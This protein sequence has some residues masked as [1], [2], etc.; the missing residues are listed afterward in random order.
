MK[1][2]FQKLQQTNIIPKIKIISYTTM[3]INFTYRIRVKRNP[4]KKMNYK[5]NKAML[6]IN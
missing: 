4:H 5:T 1:L 3:N 6:V 2:L